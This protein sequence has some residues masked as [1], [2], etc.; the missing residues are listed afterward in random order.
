MHSKRFVSPLSLFP[1]THLL[2]HLCAQLRVGKGGLWFGST[3][4]CSIQPGAD[5]IYSFGGGGERKF[6]HYSELASDYTLSFNFL[7]LH[8]KSIEDCTAFGQ[9]QKQHVGS[10]RVCADD[11]GC[12]QGA[13]KSCHELQDMERLVLAYVLKVKDEGD[14]LC[15]VGTVCPE[16]SME[17]IRAWTTQLLSGLSSIRP[18]GKKTFERGEIL[19]LYPR[20]WCTLGPWK[21]SSPGLICH[22]PLALWF[23]LVLKD[24]AVSLPYTAGQPRLKL[25]SAAQCTAAMCLRQLCVREKQWDPNVFSVCPL[26]PL[27][28]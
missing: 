4:S 7:K 25:N 27:C 5:T 8:G 22:Q 2:Q 19:D 23:N 26:F 18:E 14:G 12:W 15:M 1:V 6:T 16:P 21:E 28:P 17:V 24:R 9:C 20:G 3:R 11:G 10:G 13:W